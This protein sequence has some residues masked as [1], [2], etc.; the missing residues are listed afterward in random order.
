[1]R[2]GGR[3]CGHPPS[4]IWRTVGKRLGVESETEVFVASASYYSFFGL[5]CVE[6]GEG[7]WCGT[8]T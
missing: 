1:M 5:D 4:C 6:R 8:G 7:N 3:M 2:V